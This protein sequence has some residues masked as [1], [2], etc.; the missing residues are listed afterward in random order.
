M[1]TLHTFLLI[2]HVAGGMIGLITGLLNIINKK[3]ARYHKL[4]GKIYVGGMFTATISGTVLAAFGGNHFLFLIGIFS[5]YLAFSGL[6]S[7]Q[8]KMLNG[9]IHYA[10]LD[11]L[12]AGLTG[13]FGA[14]MIVLAAIQPEESS[15]HIA[16]IL[17]V[18]GSI[19]L[20]F[21]L[22]DLLLFVGVRKIKDLKNR[23]FFN[24][25]G[26]MIGSYISAVTAFLVVNLDNLLPPLVIWLGPTVIGTIF[27]TGF[28]TYYKRKFALGK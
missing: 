22:G 18:F 27:I 4:F 5:F 19:S 15:K 8:H 13:I 7:I 11:K 14:L 26:R 16:P 12:V 3:G 10:I 17:L 1:K 20:I 24:H 6:R 25:I 28:T 9:E 2:L 21:S 23:W